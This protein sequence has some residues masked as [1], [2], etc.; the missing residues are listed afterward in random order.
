VLP[1]LDS[2]SSRAGVLIVGLNPFRIFDGSYQGFLGLIAGQIGSAIA[3]VQAYEEERRRA[4]ALAELDRAKTVFFSNVS[5]EFRT[6]LTLMLG[7]LEDLLAEPNDNLPAEK[8]SLVDVAHR[9]GLRLLK[10]VNA[11]LDFSRLE[12]G[13]V[14]VTYEPTDLA[15]FTAELAS[16]FRSATDRAGLQLIIDPEPLPEPAFVDRDMWEKIVLNLVSNAFKFTFQGE[17]RVTIRRS[18][19]DARVAEMVVSDTGTGIPADALPRLFERFHRVEGAK[20]RSY[21]GSGI[22][23]ALVQELVRLHGGQVRV[24]SR[25]D[26][27]S[28]FTVSIPLGR[29]HLPQERISSATTPATAESRAAAFVEEALRWIPDSDDFSTV[30]QVSSRES[31]DRSRLSGSLSIAVDAPRIVLADDNADMRAYVKRLLLSEG[32]CVDAVADGSAALSAAKKATPNL[33]LSDVMMP[34]LDGFGLIRELREDPILKNVPVVLLS[35]R[36]GEDAKVEG[37]DAGADD[38]LIKPF[39]A[40]ELLARVKAT[41]RSQKFVVRLKP[42]CVM[43]RALLKL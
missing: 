38:Y 31:E 32:Y 4:D 15:T 16:S 35:A 12:A 42:P 24:K 7:P 5:H 11:L 34:G 6:P 39:S 28:T 17:I 20:G 22:G 14:K 8:R 19:E 1:V 30:N 2:E 18:R 13:R 23:L 43:R 10:L 40:R 29:D 36:A 27:G 25:I 37:F 21:E 41:L 3:N 9:N 26:E 33:V